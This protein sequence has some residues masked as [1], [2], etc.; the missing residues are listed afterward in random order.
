MRIVWPVLVIANVL[1]Y[2]IILLKLSSLNASLKSLCT[3]LDE[4][5]RKM[6]N[7]Y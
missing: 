3:K 6:D 4:I 5:L 2:I 1:T 7:W